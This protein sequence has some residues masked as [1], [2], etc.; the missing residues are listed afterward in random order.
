MVMR[1]YYGYTYAM[2]ASLLPL[3]EIAVLSEKRSTESHL[4]LRSDKLRLAVRMKTFRLAMRTLRPD[5]ERL[6]QCELQSLVAGPW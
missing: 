3:E 4:H 5:E 2:G 6:S 1:T